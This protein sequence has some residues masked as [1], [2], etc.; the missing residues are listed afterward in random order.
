MLRSR[1]DTIAASLDE[2]IDLAMRLAAEAIEAGA[3][4]RVPV[5]SGDLR[6][7]IHV[8]KQDEGSYSVIAGDSKVFY[9]H[10]VE[11]GTTKTPPRPFLIPAAE[12]ERDNIDSLVRRAFGDL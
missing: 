9:G 2:E 6:D 7:S 3:K 8:V 5:D 4:S 12:A 11:S 10:L 1:L